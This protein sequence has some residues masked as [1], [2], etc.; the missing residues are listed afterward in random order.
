MTERIDVSLQRLEDECRKVGA[1]VTQQR[2][3][4]LRILAAAEGHPDART[5][6]QRVR[7]RMPTISFDTVY[8]TLSFLEEHGLIDRVY[9]TGERAR[10]DGNVSPH[11]H[12]I[13]TRCGKIL[14]FE[15]KE[16]DRMGLS[17]AIAGIGHPA[18]KQ[19]QVLGT[20]KTCEERKSAEP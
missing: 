2:R 12:F 15:S 11:H 8:R 17:S 6:L 10:F 4:V 18:S 5:V 3:E 13:C 1:R 14:D 16:L 9:T 7:R 20:C 19:L